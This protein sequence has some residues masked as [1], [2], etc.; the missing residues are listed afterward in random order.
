LVVAF[1]LITG[2][3]R[4]A[5]RDLPQ[6]YVSAR[7]WLDGD[8]AYLPLT[9]LYDRYGFPPAESDV[10][11]RYNPHP[12]VAILLTIPFAVTRFEIAVRLVVWTQVV[13]LAF[14]WVLSYELFRPRVSGW[15]WALAGGAFGFWAPVWQGLAWGQ[16]IGFLAL[17]TLGIWWLAQSE[18]A[19][20]FGILLAT[21][22]LV[23]PFVA[24]LVVLACG[25]SIRRQCRTAIALIVGGLSPFIALLI[26]PW[27][28]YRVASYA[29][30]YV[31]ECG[32]IPGVLHI[33]A[34]GGMICF[35]LAIIVLALLGRYRLSLDSTASLAAVVALLVYPL[36]W[37][38]YDACLLPAI[39]WVMARITATG[40]RSAFWALSAY[41]LLRTIP[42][43]MPTVNGTGFV[44]ILARH[45]DWI[46]VLARG[47]L[48]GA[49]VAVATRPR[50]DELTMRRSPDGLSSGAA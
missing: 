26:W 13:A 43:L 3:R 1:I 39:A 44:E 29:S 17:S 45:K 40:N 18:R 22:I 25:W 36:A 11:V 34:T 9:E 10:K 19:V 16:P 37:F 15:V 31:S 8:S 20:G 32:S 6:D 35:L 27:E 33:G 47:I 42:D 12:P 4:V 50:S 49:V 38:Q 41:L 14:T 21:A 5:G 7:A 23:R 46:Q 30:G 28:W 48:L 2:D 24:T